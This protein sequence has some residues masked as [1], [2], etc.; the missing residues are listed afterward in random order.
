MFNLSVNTFK[1][2]IQWAIDEGYLVEERTGYRAESFFKIIKHF[3]WKNEIQLH[4]HKI[5]RKKTLNFKAVL[6]ELDQMLFHDSN[7]VPK[8]KWELL[9]Q[10]RK[11]RNVE[12]KAKNNAVAG[13]VS[14]KTMSVS[15]SIRQISST[16]GC[17]HGRASQIMNAKTHL[18]SPEK[19]TKYFDAS[20]DKLLM[21]DHLVQS[22]PGAHVCFLPSSNR[23][24]VS[25]Q[26]K[27]EISRSRAS[28]R[29]RGRKIG[30]QQH[31][32]IAERLE[33]LRERGEF[34]DFNTTQIASMMFPEGKT[35]TKRDVFAGILGK[36]W[37]TCSTQGN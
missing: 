17:G 32:L 37:N 12:K 6:L 15:S 28:F 18:Y 14:N 25:W 31:V 13:K 29:V 35:L 33:K 36:K 5:L 21:F 19:Q 23:F 7:L 9:D 3:C 10:D 34:T 26:T 22:N 20:T 24:K 30:E 27:F 16:L 1:A 4:N 8:V 2:Y 11:S